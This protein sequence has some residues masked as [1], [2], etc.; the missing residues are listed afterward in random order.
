MSREIRTFLAK[1]ASAQQADTDNGD[2]STEPAASYEASTGDAPGSAAA[3]S[4]T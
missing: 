4:A 1:H 2:T 3:D